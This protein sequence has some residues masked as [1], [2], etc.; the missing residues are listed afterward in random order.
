[1]CFLEVDCSTFGLIFIMRQGEDSH[2]LMYE[3]LR[4]VRA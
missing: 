4:V 1:M 3:N 2:N